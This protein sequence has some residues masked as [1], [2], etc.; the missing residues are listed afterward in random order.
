MIREQPEDAGVSAE[1]VDHPV[2]ISPTADFFL[3]FVAVCLLAIG[4]AALV[5]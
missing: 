5:L 4:G 3:I 2:V 1:H